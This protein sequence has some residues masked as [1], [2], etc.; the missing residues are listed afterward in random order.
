MPKKNLFIYYPK[1][2]TCIKAE[3]W[4]V[5]KGFVVEKRHIVEKNPTFE[6][7]THWI[8]LSRFPIK[9]FFNTSGMVYKSMNIKDK[10]GKITEKELVE[11]LAANGMLVKR[12]IILT[13]KGIS[14]GFNIEEWIKLLQ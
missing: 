13:E 11:L 7:L 8:N 1:C 6:E 12:P 9:K 2:S 4:L 5:E 3:K 14:V 10:F